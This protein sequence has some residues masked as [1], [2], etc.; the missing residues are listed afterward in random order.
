M[1][2]SNEEHHSPSYYVEIWAILLV[3][4]IIS[5]CGPMLEI[6][7]LTI[8]TA[9]GIAIIKAY[10]VAS[11]FMHLNVEKKY[12]SYLL[13]A[14]LLMVFIFFI[15]TAPDVMA[16]HGVEWFRFNTSEVVAP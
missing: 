8:L 2:H 3:L 7:W 12:I 1:S 10:L 5:V 9:F 4:F 16:P 6:R 15:G 13:L 14:M 11:R